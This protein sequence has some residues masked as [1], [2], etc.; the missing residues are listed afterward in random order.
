MKVSKE[1]ESLKIVPASKIHFENKMVLDMDY[2]QV[3]R[4]KNSV[5]RNHLSVK[6]LLHWTSEWEDVL[7]QVKYQRLLYLYI[8]SSLRYA[9]G[10]DYILLGSRRL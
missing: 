2:L 6:P 3:P 1:K 8:V 10:Q 4:R 9:F 7:S 5:G